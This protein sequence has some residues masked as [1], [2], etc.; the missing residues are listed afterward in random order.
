MAQVILK[1]SRV[2]Q[3]AVYVAAVWNTYRTTLLRLCDVIVQLSQHLETDVALFQETEEYRALQVLARATCEGIC[4]SVAYHLNNDWLNS[5]TEAA[6]N[7][8][9]KALG[10]LFLIWPLYGGSILSIVP[11][12]LRA[13]MRQKL[14]SIGTSLGLAQ[15]VIL[16]DT[17]DLRDSTDPLK[18]L[19]I[20]QGHTFMW[21][22]SMF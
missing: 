13:W 2:D 19:V 15:A 10:G 5:I 21:S 7:A 12:E 20:A 8:S 14:R 16:A 3:D 22:A 4:S 17:V 11:D 1:G 9:T 18:P 6:S